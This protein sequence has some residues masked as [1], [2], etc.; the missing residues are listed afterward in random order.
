MHHI[1]WLKGKIEDM[2][3]ETLLPYPIKAKIS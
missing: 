2:D 1:F 3:I